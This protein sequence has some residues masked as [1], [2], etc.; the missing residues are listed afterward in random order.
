M[1]KRYRYKKCKR[2]L[3]SRKANKMHNS[4]FNVSAK[5]DLHFLPSQN[6]LCSREPINLLL[7]GVSNGIYYDEVAPLFM[8]LQSECKVSIILEIVSFE[9]SKFK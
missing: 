4:K 3:N 7:S 8:R 1:Y 9:E 5:C 6:C 2:G